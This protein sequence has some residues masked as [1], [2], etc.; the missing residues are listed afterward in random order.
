MVEHVELDYRGKKV[1]AD[2]LSVG[3]TTVGRAHPSN[4]RW[5][6]TVDGVTQDGFQGGPDD[7]KESVESGVRAWLAI[8]E[9]RPKLPYLDCEIEP[10]P[11]QVTGSSKW[12]VNLKLLRNH[13][14]EFTE[15]LVSMSNEFASR[16]EA[17]LHGFLFGQKVVDGEI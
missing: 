6:I 10:V 8:R 5:H 3:V 4:A 1:T 12:R 13:Q 14:G 17:V 2:C 11:L 7:T 16:E 9:Q 15:Q